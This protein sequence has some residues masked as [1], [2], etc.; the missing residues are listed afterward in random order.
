MPNVHY[1]KRKLLK[2]TSLNQSNLLLLADA[3]SAA[4]A[5]E[6]NDQTFSYLGNGNEAHS[7]TCPNLVDEKPMQ[8]MDT[9]IQNIIPP[10]SQP[11]SS[12][13]WN[14]HADKVLIDYCSYFLNSDGSIGDEKWPPL[15]HELGTSAASC[16]MRW[17]V[18][19]GSASKATWEK[20]Q[21]YLR[22]K[23]HHSVHHQDHYPAAQHTNDEPT[24]T[25]YSS[26]TAL[27]HPEEEY[28]N[29]EF[30]AYLQQ[31][32][33]EDDEFVRKV[34]AILDDNEIKLLLESQPPMRVE[35]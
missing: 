10:F 2:K 27:T 12:F 5:D 30:D 3:S 13:T 23:L 4:V 21:Q 7:Q 11:R 28:Y 35:I 17:H 31:V 33:W 1:D 20:Q 29:P 32:L 6:N 14:I 22:Q 18:L 24:Q 26:T 25:T 34:E 19:K 8:T 16:R 15:A 9:V